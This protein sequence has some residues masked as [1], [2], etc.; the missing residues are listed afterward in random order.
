MDLL[1]ELQVKLVYEEK[2]RKT[3]NWKSNIG[4][5]PQDFALYSELTAEENVEFFC[6]LYGFKGKELKGVIKKSIK[7]CW[8]K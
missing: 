1:K 8:I 6:S 5:V 4:V 7:F 3:R 2:E